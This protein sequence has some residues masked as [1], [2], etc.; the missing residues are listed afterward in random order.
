MSTECNSY[1]KKSILNIKVQG[2]KCKD[3][4]PKN[5]GVAHP[6]QPG[7]YPNNILYDKYLFFKWSIPKYQ[8]WSKVD[9]RLF[10]SIYRNYK[11]AHLTTTTPTPENIIIRHY[12]KHIT[13][14]QSGNFL[15]IF[16]LHLNFGLSL[17]KKTEHRSTRSHW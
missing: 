3:S 2:Q 16:S 6:I 15:E 9:L 11:S 7:I 10:I 12:L 4:H 17:M 8:A 13:K 1:F 14:L 5:I